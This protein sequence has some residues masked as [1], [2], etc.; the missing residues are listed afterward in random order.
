[1]KALS[2]M[3]S[4]AAGWTFGDWSHDRGPEYLW[5]SLAL[6]MVSFVFYCSGEADEAR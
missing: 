1:M 4:A 5:I 3:A 2:Y 6:M